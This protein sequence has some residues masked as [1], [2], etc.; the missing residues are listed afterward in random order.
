MAFTSTKVAK[1]HSPVEEL[2]TTMKNELVTVHCNP[3]AGVTAMR[4]AFDGNNRATFSDLQTKP[5]SPHRGV[6]VII[7]SLSELVEHSSGLA[8][9]TD[10]KD[11]RGY[12]Q[13]CQGN[14]P[15]KGNLCIH[16][17]AAALP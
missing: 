5:R 3:Q 14:L 10:D 4:D 17:R 16:H 1:L 2:R 11:R 13:L 15:G 6:A 9:V 7:I 12:P 8:R